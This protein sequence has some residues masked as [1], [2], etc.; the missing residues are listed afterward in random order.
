M[1][2]AKT[3]DM[4]GE[5]FGRNQETPIGGSKSIGHGWLRSPAWIAAA[6]AA[7]VFLSLSAR[8]E[9]RAQTITFT[10]LHS[11]TGGTNDGAYP[12]TDLVRDSSGNQY[13]ATAYGGPANKG[14]VFKI[15]TDGVFRVIHSFNGIDGAF[16]AG[17]LILDSSGNLYGTT[18]RGGT[19]EDGTVFKINAAGDETVLYNFSGGADGEQ[20]VASLVWDSSGNLCG[21]TSRGGTAGNGTVF[22]IK[23]DG[24]NFRVLHNFLG[25][26]DGASPHA[27]LVRDASGNLYGTTYFG[28]SANKGIVFKIDTDGTFSV[29]HSFSGIDGANPASDLIFDPSGDLYGT[30]ACGGYSIIVYSGYEGWG[31][32]YKVSPDGSNFIVLHDFLGG[33]DG[34]SPYAGLVRD[35]SGNLYGTTTEGGTEASGTVFKID[36]ANN[37]SVIHNFFW[38]DGARPAADLVLDALGNLYGT[39]SYSYGELGQYGTAFKIAYSFPFSSFSAKL[40]ISTGPPPQFQLQAFFTLGTGAPAIDPVTQGLTLTIGTCTMTIPP[41]S[42]HQTKKGWWVYEG[43]RGGV[44]L[45]VRISQRGANPYELQMEGSGADLAPLANPVTV[46]LALGNNNGATQAPQ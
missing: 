33:L 15:D 5:H 41:G 17:D 10:V 38:N 8:R 16:P 11:F 18:A 6:L 30:T 31:T 20:P 12:S 34:A 14:T 28:G 1:A 24:S 13:G 44:A 4:T 27:G 35:S 19:A 9:A 7:A 42:F 43:M 37:F 21:T 22:Q 3:R 45:E 32:V 40:D 29:I 26:F 39:T 23:A 36:V 46:S 2:S 25:G